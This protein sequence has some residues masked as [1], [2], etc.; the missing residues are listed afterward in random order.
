M[1]IDNFLSKYM[2]EIKCFIYGCFVAFLGW[3]AI[4]VPFPAGGII[5]A[6]AH[7]CLFYEGYLKAYEDDVINITLIGFIF[8]SL[9][10]SFIAPPV[11][12]IYLE[13]IMLGSLVGGLVYGF[14]YSLR[15]TLPFSVKAMILLTA[16]LCCPVLHFCSIA[17]MI[18]IIDNYLL[19]FSVYIIY[20]FYFFLIYFIINKKDLLD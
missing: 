19:L 18:Y 11:A 13:Y 15:D 17:Q 4:T 7:L 2:F 5:A 1:I 16:H 12:S 9:C 3:F 6:I 20:W 10:L 14:I 8:A